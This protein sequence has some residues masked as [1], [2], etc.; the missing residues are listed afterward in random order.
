MNKTR[1]HKSHATV[2]LKSGEIREIEKIIY[3]M[4]KKKERRILSGDEKME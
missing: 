1:G 4:K 3:F 2:P